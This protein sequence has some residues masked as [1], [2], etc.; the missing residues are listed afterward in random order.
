VS[1][2]LLNPSD[3]KRPQREVSAAELFSFLTLLLA[4]DE[5]FKIIHLL[6]RR[7]GANMREIQRCTGISYRKVS[8]SLTSL[9][10]SG[11]VDVYLVGLGMRVYRLSSKC[12]ILRM[13]SPRSSS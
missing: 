3:E 9:V 1:P 12:E 8:R 5:K 10:E 13:L 11:A 6:A 4:E 2:G 7:E